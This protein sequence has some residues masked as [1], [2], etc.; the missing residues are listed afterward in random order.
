MLSL[1]AAWWDTAPST[2]APDL[3]SHLHSASVPFPSPS[4]IILDGCQVFKSTWDV[5]FQRPGSLLGSSALQAL[6]LSFSSEHLSHTV[7][8]P[9]ARGCSHLETQIFIGQ[10]SHFGFD[11]CKGCVSNFFVSDKEQSQQSAVSRP[12]GDQ[13]RWALRK[14]RAAG[15]LPTVFL[16]FN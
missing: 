5:A 2:T 3:P 4:V 16:N 8:V 13:P 1:T 7:T 6:V 10:M 9:S 15:K 12:A 14:H 11:F